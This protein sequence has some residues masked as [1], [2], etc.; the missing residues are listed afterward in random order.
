MR[1]LPQTNF[2]ETLA[3]IYEQ[4][5]SKPV[6]LTWAVRELFDELD[7]VGYISLD[8]F[9]KLGQEIL[10]ISGMSLDRYDILNLIND[11]L[12]I[13]LD[14]DEDLERVEYAREV[15]EQDYFEP[16]DDGEED[17]Y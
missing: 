8:E 14:I 1:K 7:G 16:R 4:K 15:G 13:D 2:D 11:K 10:N 17:Y 6:N 12:G 3:L 9:L 5:I